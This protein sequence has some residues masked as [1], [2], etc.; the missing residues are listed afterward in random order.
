[1]DTASLLA[2][3]DP[4]EL[5]YEATSLIAWEIGAVSSDEEVA[6]FMYRGGSFPPQASAKPP[7][8]E[9]RRPDQKYWN[10]V[11]AEMRLFLCTDNKKY[12]ALWKQIAELQKKS[13]TAIVGLIAA[14]LGEL[15]GAPAALLAGF[16]AVCLYAVLKVGKEAYCNFT[17]EN[18]D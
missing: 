4:K 7:T 8:A 9:D 13:T 5:T 6:S 2:T 16:V 14:F 18:E 15:V 11:K 10:Y 1:M 3:I 17:A 12:R